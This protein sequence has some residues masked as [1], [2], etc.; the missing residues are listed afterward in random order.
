MLLWYPYTHGCVK[1]SADRSP[2]AAGQRES[3]ATPFRS[4]LESF[5]HLYLVCALFIGIILILVSAI[6]RTSA[7]SE[8]LIDISRD[9]GIGF[10][11]SVLVVTFIE[12]RAGLTL[13]TEIAEDVLEAVFRRI[14]PDVIFDQVR[15][16][17]FRSDVLRRDWQIQLTILPVEENRAAYRAVRDQA[18]TEQVYLIQST[19]T[20]ALENLNDSDI[21]FPLTHGIDS[22]LSIEEHGIPCFTELEFGGDLYRF[23]PTEI[24]SRY[25]E[26]ESFVDRGLTLSR[27]P[28]E[29][30]AEKTVQINRA[31]TTVVR[32]KLIRA[33]RVPG[34]YVISCATPADGVTVQISG[35]SELGFDVRPLHP[36]ARHIAE[37]ESGRR[38]TFP[39]GM[40]PW[41]GIQIVSYLGRDT[42]PRI[43]PTSGP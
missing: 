20:Y 42:P 32:Y 37:S 9:I 35:V 24:F 28:N 25:G 17:T 38:W 29:M 11:V 34:I 41:Q 3:S 33:L 43:A 15:D 27:E 26:G 7:D 16:S 10:I 2:V 23:E 18:K 4:L 12:W 14:V 40:L 13:R 8:Y 1:S 5:L 39:Y 36:Q 22:E 6:F 30:L 19:V 31:G 21:S